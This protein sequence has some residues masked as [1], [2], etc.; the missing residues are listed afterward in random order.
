MPLRGRESWEELEPACWPS[1]HPRA[2]AEKKKKTTR[3]PAL[4]SKVSYPSTCWH[5]QAAREGRAAAYL[6][7]GLA[8][9]CSGWLLCKA[10]ELRYLHL[11]QQKGSSTCRCPVS[12]LGSTRST[13]DKRRASFPAPANSAPRRRRNEAIAETLGYNNIGAS[14]TQYCRP[15][16]HTPLIPVYSFVLPVAERILPSRR[17]RRAE[18]SC[19]HDGDSQLGND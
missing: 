19:A 5:G 16:T 6:A 3:L 9:S 1:R 2:S 17:A 15:P 10:V 11:E 8:V 4:P 18:I 7:V 13:D 14:S 12:M